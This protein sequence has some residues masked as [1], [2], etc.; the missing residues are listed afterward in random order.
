VPVHEAAR[1]PGHRKPASAPGSRTA[2]RSADARTVRVKRL[3]TRPG[4]RARAPSR[5][6]TWTA[7]NAAGSGC[8]RVAGLPLAAARGTEQSVDSP[9]QPQSG[10]A[11]LARASR[12]CSGVVPVQRLNA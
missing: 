7:C 3:C 10:A 8:A 2:A 5:G 11:P 1:E 9:R 6:S 12:A 4:R